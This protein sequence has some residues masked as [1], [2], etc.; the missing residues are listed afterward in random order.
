VV[1]HTVGVGTEAG[2]PVP[3]FDPD[4]RRIGFKHDPSGAA[5]IS[6]LNMATLEE[7]ARGT[8][9]RAFR[10]TPTDPAL[11]A[12][13]LAIEGMEQKTMAREFSYRRKERFQI[14]LGVGLF[15]LALSFLLPPPRLRR[16]A[17]LAVRAA[18]LLLPLGVAGTPRAQAQPAPGAAPPVTPGA[19]SA[20]PA[21]EGGA[22]PGLVDELLLRPSRLTAEGRKQYAG[23][24]HPQALSAFERAARARPQ[25]PRGRFNLGDGLYKNGKFDEAATLFRSLGENPA[26]PLA[27]PSRFNL[28]NAL[29]QKKDY[30]G[31]IQGYR[32]A[33]RLAPGD[34]DARRNLELALRALKQQEELRSSNNSKSR[35]GTRRSSSEQGEQKPRPG[36]R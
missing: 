30:R 11:S 33:L 3:E 23:G 26:S 29:F 34:L 8:G 13:A 32:D 25:D 19:E 10:I 20:P 27:Q 28:G 14:P 35:T 18:A 1:V 15:A 4:G 31:A 16:R 5:V 17:A 21:A 6:R 2:Q 9:G 24:N 22:K 12:L 7:I 36:S